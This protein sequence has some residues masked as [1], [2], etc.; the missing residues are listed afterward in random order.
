MNRR[1]G[2]HGPG[3]SVTGVAATGAPESFVHCWMSTRF[4]FV[5]RPRGGLSQ[6]H[7]QIQEKH[8]HEKP[9]LH[10]LLREHSVWL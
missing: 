8:I 3:P 7:K 10:N 9:N 1:T 4:D 5:A 2:D 6:F